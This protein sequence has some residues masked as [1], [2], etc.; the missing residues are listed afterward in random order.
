MTTNIFNKRHKAILKKHNVCF[1]EDCDLWSLVR[2]L[3]YYKGQ[4]EDDGE[5]LVHIT[6]IYYDSNG[7]LSGD[8]E[9]YLKLLDSELTDILKSNKEKENV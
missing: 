4:P 5:F 9:K 3:I 6:G 8:L 2:G 7:V 1:E